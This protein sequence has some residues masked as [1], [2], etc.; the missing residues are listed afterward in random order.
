MWISYDDCSFSFLGGGGFYYA[1]V[2]WGEKYEELPHNKAIKLW[3]HSM[4][5]SCFP[6]KKLWVIYLSL[7]M[8]HRRK[9]IDTKIELLMSFDN[10][11]LYFN[12]HY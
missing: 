1:C 10:N 2:G 9:Y 4:S 6:G 12:M 8:M 11:K 7:K 5:T 3:M